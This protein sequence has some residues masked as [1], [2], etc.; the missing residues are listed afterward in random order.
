VLLCCPRAVSFG[1]ISVSIYGATYDM[2]D[3]SN[4]GY[5]YSF[6]M[7]CAGVALSALSTLMFF[8]GVRDSFS[9]SFL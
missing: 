9:Y 2:G 5:G 1:I 8:F 3:G 6:G 4:G 7:M